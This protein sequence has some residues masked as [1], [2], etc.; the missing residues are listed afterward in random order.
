MTSPFEKLNVEPIP[1]VALSPAEAAL[2]AGLCERTLSDLV[3]SGEIPS[4]K[5]GRRRLIPVR[6][7]RKWLSRRSEG[8]AE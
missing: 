4:V 7:L 8:G 6:E 5:V 2:S 1:R 3:V